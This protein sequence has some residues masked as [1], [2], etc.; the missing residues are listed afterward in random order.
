MV[1]TKN[2]AEE[3]VK[4]ENGASEEEKKEEKKH[5]VEYADSETKGVVSNQRQSGKWI[6]KLIVIYSSIPGFECRV[7]KKWLT[8]FAQWYRSN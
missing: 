7:C 8:D 4:K 3:E 1:E 6:G 5:D 2:T